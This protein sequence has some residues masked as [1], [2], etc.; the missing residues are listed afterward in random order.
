MARLHVPNTRHHIFVGD[1]T[2]IWL[3]PPNQFTGCT[4]TTRGMHVALWP[5]V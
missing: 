2:T 3:W 1:V 4:E 5:N